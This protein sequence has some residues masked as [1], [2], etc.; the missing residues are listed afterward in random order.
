MLVEGRKQMSILIYVS[1]NTLNPFNTSH[2]PKIH[3][4]A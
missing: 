4:R 2:S 3:A 1:N